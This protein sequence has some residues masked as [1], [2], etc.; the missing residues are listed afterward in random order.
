M[1]HAVDRL[2][3]LGPVE[4]GTHVNRWHEHIEHVGLMDR[5]RMASPVRDILA[6]DRWEGHLRYR[7]FLRH[8]A[9]REYRISREPTRLSSRDTM[10]LPRLT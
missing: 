7:S 4:M 1:S 2:L 5:E 6:R 9:S 3:E 10:S 8:L